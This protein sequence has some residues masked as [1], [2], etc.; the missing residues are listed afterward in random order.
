[1][2]YTRTLAQKSESVQFVF[3]GGLLAQYEIG[4]FALQA[5]EYAEYRFL[6]LGE[7]LHIVNAKTASR[8][9]HCLQA[10]HDGTVAYLE[11]GQPQT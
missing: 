5:S 3:Y 10:L 7:A 6:P 9:P 11:D 8:L 4:Q 1:M 2:D